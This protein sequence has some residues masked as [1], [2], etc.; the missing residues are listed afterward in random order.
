[1]S[2]SG[3]RGDYIEQIDAMGGA[4]RAIEAG[5]YQDE[6]HEAAF[7][8]QQGI[9]SGERVVVGVNRF[10]DAGE[11]E[12]VELQRI[13]EAETASRWSGCARC[14]PGEISPRS[15]RRWWRWPRRPQA[16]PTCCRR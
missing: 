7:R 6:I 14:E 11:R 9:E 4:V 5:F 15:T 10:V 13:S 2:S 1:M 8:V 12:P 3:S 16:P